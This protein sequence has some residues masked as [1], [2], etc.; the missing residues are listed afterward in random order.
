MAQLRQRFLNVRFRSVGLLF[1]S[2]HRDGV[3][4][5]PLQF[6]LAIPCNKYTHSAYMARKPNSNRAPNS[7]RHLRETLGRNQESFAAKHGLSQRSLQ[8]WESGRESPLELREALSTEYGLAI[9]SLS[10]PDGIARMLDGSPVTGDLL[11]GWQTALNQESIPDDAFEHLVRNTHAVLVAAEGKK[12]AGRV[13]IR[14]SQELQKLI[15]EHG[16]QTAVEEFAA[17]PVP[18]PVIKATI[19]EA[20]K[21]IAE[22][23]SPAATRWRKESR[24]TSLSMPC[25]IIRTVRPKYVPAVQWLEVDIQGVKHGGFTMGGSKLNIHRVEVRSGKF[26][27]RM[28]FPKWKLA[29]FVNCAISPLP[30]VKPSKAYRV[31]RRKT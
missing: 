6:V 16:L 24:S 19:L 3:N 17:A 8:S 7:L 5:S 15:N 27:F 28:E 10:A 14:L 20:G 18:L 12:I 31:A 1:V 2:R 30:A 23:E 4:Y 22:I 13:F 11:S 9:G 21:M 26:R 29:N 25:E